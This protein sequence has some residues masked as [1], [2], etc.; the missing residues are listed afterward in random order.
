MMTVNCL[1]PLSKVKLWDASYL[2]NTRLDVQYAVSR[3][4][5]SLRIQHWQAVKRVFGHL[6]GTKYD[7]LMF[8]RG[9]L[10]DACL[11]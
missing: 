5:H 8:P 10:A 4:M 9:C 3:F 1:T 7:D 2:C 6:K 11:Q